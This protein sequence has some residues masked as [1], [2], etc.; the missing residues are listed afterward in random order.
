[1][2][3]TTP[4]EVVLSMFFMLCGVSMVALLIGSMT[5]LLTQATSDAR[6][7]HALRQKMTEVG[8][9]SVHV[10]S[11]ACGQMNYQGA[12]GLQAPSHAHVCWDRG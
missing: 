11:S 12:A 5:E 2:L 9:G 8:V 1:M 6:R 4:L 3:P 7:A 10:P